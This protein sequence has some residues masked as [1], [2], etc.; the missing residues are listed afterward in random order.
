M[1]RATAGEASKSLRP[2]C[3]VTIFYIDKDA[4]GTGTGEYNNSSKGWVSCWSALTF[5]F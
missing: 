3:R 1:I 4:R 5:W 2:F